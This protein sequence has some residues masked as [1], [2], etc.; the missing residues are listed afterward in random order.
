M[1]DPNT[2]YIDRGV[3]GIGQATGDL[4]EYDE[5]KIKVVRN[6]VGRLFLI[7]HGSRRPDN[8]TIGLRAVPKSG[9]DDVYRFEVC[10]IICDDANRLSTKMFEAAAPLDFDQAA[11][12]SVRTVEI[13]GVDTKV[14]GNPPIRTVKCTRIYVVT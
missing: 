10:Q 1:S 8:S 9:A 5:T 3:I 14:S 7:V 12:G 4:S 2:N 11:A 6:S 13:M